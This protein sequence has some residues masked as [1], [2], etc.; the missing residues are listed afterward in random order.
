MLRFGAIMFCAFPFPVILERRYG[1]RR[2]RDDDDDDDDF[3]G[4]SSFPPT[5]FPYFSP[6]S[7]TPPV[8]LPQRGEQQT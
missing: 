6:L 2:L 5:A 7:F 8:P 4:P 3:R 1:P